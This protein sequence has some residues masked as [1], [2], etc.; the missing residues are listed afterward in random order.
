MSIRTAYDAAATAWG[1]AHPGARGHA[2]ALDLK[3][4]GVLVCPGYQFG[5]GVPAAFRINFSQDGARL[6]RAA[7]RIAAVLGHG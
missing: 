7:Q 6:E 3:G 2:L 5:L 4:A 1:R